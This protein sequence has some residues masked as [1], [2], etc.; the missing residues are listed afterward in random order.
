MLGRERASLE[1]EKDELEERW[2]ERSTA[3]D[4][5]REAFGRDP[6]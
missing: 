4:A 6:G 5:E 3:R 2:L 1:R